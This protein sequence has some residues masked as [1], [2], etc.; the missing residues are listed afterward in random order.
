M[1]A[2]RVYRN[3][4]YEYY[5]KINSGEVVVGEWIK[6]VYEIV[7]NELEKGSY[8]FN[9]KKAN[10]AIKF[11]E[12]FC[13]HSQGRNDYLTLELWQKALISCIFGIV[14][15]QNIRFFREIFIVVGRKNGKSLFAS[16]IIAYM[17]F[18]E[19]E[20]GQEIYCLAP[21]LEQAAKVY[22]AFLQMVDKEPELKEEAR[23][24]RSDLYID[25]T[26]SFVKPIAFNA[27]KS[28][29]FNPQLVVC[30]EI[31]AWSGD[32]GLKQYEVMKSALG[33]R[34]Q[35]MILSISTA[36]YI[37]DSIYD[38][39]YKRSTSV[40]KGNSKERRL[41][42]FLYMIDDVDKWNDLEELKKANP[43]MG[44]SVTAEFFQEEIA[45]AEGSLSKKAEFLCKY[46]NIKQ[47]SAT[48][49]LES[50]VV[51]KATAVKTIDGKETPYT[52]EDF[53]E[54]YAVGGVDLSQTTDLTAACVVIEREGILYTFCQFFMPAGRIEALT[55]IDGIAYDI[56]VKKGVLT[57]SGEN[58]V[59]YHDVY[60]WYVMLMEKYG[61]RTLKIGYDR[62][63]AQYLISELSGYGF[64]VDDV[65]QGENL[66][67]VIREFEG[68]IKDGNFK[69]CSNNL[70]KGHF[71]NVA[72]KQNMETR[73]FRPVKIERRAHI[74][75]FV[76][77]IDAMTVR[78]KYYEE[79][80][81]LLK[82]A[83]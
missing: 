72:L 66:T 18:L 76:A 65:F 21:K 2:A 6:K 43:N 49:W 67:P 4:I 63:S 68:I 80:G 38:E 8:F 15:D 14:D 34:R 71:L 26:N 30:D 62:Y 32:G 48:A 55:A 13:H 37:N 24:R 82:N 61:I 10:K 33:A 20:Y 35:P 60:N 59:D 16:A 7:V 39:L 25:A 56:F 54:C 1:A 69:I 44:V 83:A 52:L 40:L 23:K 58:Y 11:I 74:D 79:V 9:A 22:D 42:P 31:A 78:Q 28:D 41:L 36:G 77:V 50:L 51:E 45:V 5:A 19:P 27:K 75:G 3:Y 29:G 73:K 12:N 46:C 81:E 17:A 53:R 64:H 57:L 70:L 47:N